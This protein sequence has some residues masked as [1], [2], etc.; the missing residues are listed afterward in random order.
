[1]LYLSRIIDPLVLWLLHLLGAS[2]VAPDAEETGVTY[3]QEVDH[4]RE[5]QEHSHGQT[6]D[7]ED[8][9]ECYREGV[10]I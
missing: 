2:H 7:P 8:R 3:K 1:M 6:S 5:Q 9:T 4:H 10:E